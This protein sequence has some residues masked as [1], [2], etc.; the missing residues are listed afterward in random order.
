MNVLAQRFCSLKG[1]FV[2]NERGYRLTSKNYRFWSLLIFLLS[3][4]SIRRKVLKTTSTE[5][6]IAYI[7]IQKVAIYDLYRKII[8]LI[9]NKSFRYYTT[10]SHRLSFATFVYSWFFIICLILFF[11]II[12]SLHLVF[13]HSWKIWKCRLHYQK[14]SKQE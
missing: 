3:V 5:E 11:K 9:S 2:K 4:A 12:F 8:N 14:S 1:A 10:Y 6:N 7:Q 13:E